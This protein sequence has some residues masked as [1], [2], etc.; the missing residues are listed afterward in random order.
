M[1]HYIPTLNDVDTQATPL[2]SL[3]TYDYDCGDNLLYCNIALKMG[4]CSHDIDVKDA[5]IPCITE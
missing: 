1:S 3:E 2:I 5:V 4:S